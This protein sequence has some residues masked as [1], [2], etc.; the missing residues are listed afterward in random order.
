MAEVPAFR[1]MDRVKLAKLGSALE[2]Q[3]HPSGTNVITQGEKG[4]RF[5]ILESGEVEILLDAIEADEDGEEPIEDTSNE[6]VKVGTLMP[7]DWFGEMALLND[8]PRTASVRALG[9]IEL[10]L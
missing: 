10:S 7:G 8:A 6:P 5:Y 9:T 2:E 4:D 3:S 1:H